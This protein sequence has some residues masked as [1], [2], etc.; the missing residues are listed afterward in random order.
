CESFTSAPHRPNPQSRR[1]SG[2]ED[3]HCPGPA[4]ALR[5]PASSP[6]SPCSCHHPRG[7]IPEAFEERIE[8]RGECSARLKRG[9]RQG[10]YVPGGRSTPYGLQESVRRDGPPPAPLVPLS[11]N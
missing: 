1:L 9:L 6:P 8:H 4:P 2:A 5:A 11:G 3:S 10:C 7:F